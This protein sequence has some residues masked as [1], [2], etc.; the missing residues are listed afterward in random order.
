MLEE[1][2]DLSLEE[3]NRIVD[4]TFDNFCSATALKT[5]KSDDDEQKVQLLLQIRDFSTVVEANQAMHAGDIGR[6][7]L[8]WKKW[9]VML[10]GMKGLT[11]YSNYLPRL[12]LLLTKTLPRPVA[13]IILHGMLISP[14]GRPNHFVAK[15]FFLEVQNYW[16]KF[17]YNNTVSFV[18]G[19]YL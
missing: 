8:V 1:K 7:M 3:F 10:Q 16:I 12:V 5:A 11:H 2:L 18:F 13:K 4:T 14:S 6:L 19:T 9:G 17:F 15:D